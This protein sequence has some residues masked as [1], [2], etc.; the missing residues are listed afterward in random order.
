MVNHGVNK[1]TKQ[2]FGYIP[3]SNGDSMINIDEP[4][5]DGKQW[6]MCVYVCVIYTIDTRFSDKPTAYIKKTCTNIT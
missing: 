1:L 6:C 4:I 2:T 5:I 3:H